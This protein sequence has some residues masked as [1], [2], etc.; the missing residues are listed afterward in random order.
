MWEGKETMIR[1]PEKLL[2]YIELEEGKVVE[3]ET[4]PKE[5][6]ADYMAF[7]KTYKELQKNNRLTDL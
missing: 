6:H 1:I 4:I 3:K 2:P 5:L 7:K